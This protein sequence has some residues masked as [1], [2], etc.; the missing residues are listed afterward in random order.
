MGLGTAQ[1]KKCSGL[2]LATYA[3]LAASECA[4]ISDVR[5]S[6]DYRFRMVEVV[7]R[8]AL[9]EVLG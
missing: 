2:E 7:T 1:A 8:K 3:S 6:R 5:A 9:E 4:P